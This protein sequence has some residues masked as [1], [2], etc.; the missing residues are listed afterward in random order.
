[1]KKTTGVCATKIGQPTCSIKKIEQVGYLPDMHIASG[2]KK[3][4]EISL[5]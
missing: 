5:E 4:P 2:L 3:T 1:M